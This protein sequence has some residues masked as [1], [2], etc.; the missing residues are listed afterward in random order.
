M[1]ISNCV[2]N[3]DGS[4]DFDFHVEPSEAAFLMDKDLIHHGIINVNL[5]QAEQEFEIHKELGGSVQ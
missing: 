5:G 2:A 1:L 3:E 4:Y